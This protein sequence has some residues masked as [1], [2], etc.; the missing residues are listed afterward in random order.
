M[1]TWDYVSF[2]Q[3]GAEFEPNSGRT[4][5]P[6]C[7]RCEQLFANCWTLDHARNFDIDELSSKISTAS[8]LNTAFQW[9]PEL[10]KGHHRLSL[11]DAMGIDH[12]NPQSWE[13]NVIVG[14]VD[15]AK[16]WKA[17]QE[18]ANQLLLK[19]YPDQHAQID[20]T[21]FAS[22]KCDLLRP[23]VNMSGLEL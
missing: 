5:I 4:L 8:M 18:A 15:L 9:H 13:G 23:M 16:M 7:L 14:N 3:F 17:G 6:P 1:S 2:A 10:D 21:M 11:K 19:F 20:P 22:Q 12:I